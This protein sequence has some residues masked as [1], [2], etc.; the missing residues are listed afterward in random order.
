MSPEFPFFLLPLCPFLR[1]LPISLYSFNKFAFEM[2]TTI[3]TSHVAWT[4]NLG[5]KEIEFVLNEGDAVRS[6]VI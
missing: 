1:L 5:N 6:D 4:I 3:Y 2:Q